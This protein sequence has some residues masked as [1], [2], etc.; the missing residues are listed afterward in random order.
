MRRNRSAKFSWTGKRVLITGGSSGIGKQIAADLLRLGASVGIVA[1]GKDRLQ[2][3]EMELR[4]IAPYVWSHRC[5]IAN[6]GEVRAMTA[7]YRERFGAPD[8]LINNAGYAVYYAFEQMSSEEIYRLFQVNLVG[9]AFVTREFLPDM[10]R[11]GGGHIVMMASIAGRIPM[12]PCGVYSASKHGLVALSELVQIETRRSNIAVH[13]I[14]PGR[15]ETD[16]FSHQSFRRRRHRPESTRTIPIDAVSKAVITAVRRNTFLTYVPRHYGIL[17]WFAATA[18]TVF[19]PFWH[20]LMTSRVESVLSG[21][22][23]RTAE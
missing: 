8:V 2:A 19:K 21:P 5:D 7:A 23:D 11:A 3:A 10:I 15:V 4:Q 1:D 17:A 14:C 9:A 18:P 22:D 12:T 20:R 13:V 16:F 6:L